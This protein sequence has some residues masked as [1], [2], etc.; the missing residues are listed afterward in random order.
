M[1]SSRPAFFLMYPAAPRAIACC[2]SAG[3]S[4]MDS[5]NTGG[6]VS[7]SFSA[8]RTSRPDI[9]GMRMSSRTTSASASANPPPPRAALSPPTPPSDRLEPA[10]RRR[11][12]EADLPAEPGPVVLDL[13]SDPMAA[14]GDLYHDPGGG[15]GV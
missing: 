8:V 11:Q 4:Y 5:T 3:S 6:A 1:S 12:A 2:T 10:A 9:V 13:E 7:R 14:A 15:G